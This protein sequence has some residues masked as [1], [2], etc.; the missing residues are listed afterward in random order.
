MQKFSYNGILNDQKVDGEIESESRLTAFLNLKKKG[1]IVWSVTPLYSGIKKVKKKKVTSNFFKEKIKPQDIVSFT[2]QF[3]TMVKAGLPI[4]G[5]LEMVRDQTVNLSMKE[6]I[7]NIRKKLEGGVALSQCFSEYP[8]YFDSLYINLIKAGEASGKLDI[9]MF[10]LVLSLEKKEKI[11]KK[12]KSALMYPTIMFSVAMSVTAI[13][14]IKVVPVFA[15]M[16]DNM[17]V[18]L[19]APTAVILSMSNFLSGTGG[20][21][22]LFSL[23][24]IYIIFRYLT[25][26]NKKI[27]YFWHQRILKLPLFGNMILKSSLARISMIMSN[28]T[29]AGVNLLESLDIAKSINNNVIII[30][31]LQNV[32]TGVSSGQTLTDLFT[33][34]ELFPPAFSQLVSVG[35]QTGTLDEMFGSISI[36]YEE[37]FDN[38]VEN[39]STLIE[40]IMIVFMGTIIGG[41]M[42][43]M[44]APIFNIG[45]VM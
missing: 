37:E 6:I 41:L 33:K 15:K 26:K 43:A 17:G 12:I 14:L 5:T 21:I 11:K 39:M 38:S 24:S 20:L 7:E 3:A 27:Q 32:K 34:E 18:E 42:V 35:E 8:L 25:T 30:E 28:L 1:I 31:A 13:M 4:L 29:S 36:L 45:S 16:Y 44:Y 10:K 19:P 2:K 23:I 40:P 22:L 9:F